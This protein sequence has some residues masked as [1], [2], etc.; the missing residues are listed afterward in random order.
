MFKYK[1]PQEIKEKFTKEF[2]ADFLINL[3]QVFNLKEPI[4]YSD[5]IVYLESTGGWV[6][7]FRNACLKHNITDVFL[8][9][10]GLKWHDGDL[11]NDE[12]GNLLV[13]YGLIK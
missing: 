9:Y 3:A 12:L 2:M 5:N 6:V 8:Y 13:E 11:F 7:A 10:G 4:S 1:I